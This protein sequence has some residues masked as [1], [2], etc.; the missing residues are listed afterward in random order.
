MAKRLKPTEV[1]WEATIR[2]RPYKLTPNDL[3]SGVLRKFKGWYGPDYGAFATFAVLLQR[4]DVDAIACAIW[5][6]KEVAGEKVPRDPS[7]IQFSVVDLLPDEDEDDADEY[8]EVEGANPTPADPTSDSS[9]TLT[10]SD[11]ES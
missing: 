11:Y 2:D 9:S 8:D 10:S 4:G 3:T 6:A 5:L 1:I 7:F